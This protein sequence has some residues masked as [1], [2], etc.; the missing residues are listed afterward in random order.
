M[1][2]GAEQNAPTTNYLFDFIYLDRNKLGS[3]YAQLFDDGVLS[4]V[5]R[6]ASTQD[7]SARS[8]GVGAPK[9]LLGGEARSSETASNGIETQFDASW[10][11]PIEVINEL[12]SRGFIAKNIST[13]QLGQLVLLRGRLQIIDLRM[14]QELWEPIIAAQTEEAK[15][16]AKTALE[17]KTAATEAATNKQMIKVISKLPHTMQMR[18][19]NDEYQAWSTLSPSSLT[20]NA[21]DLA[22]KHGASMPG[23]WWTLALLDAR[24]ADDD[25]FAV[26][27]AL[28]DIESGMLQMLIGLRVFFGRQSRDY[29]VTPVAV[30]RSVSPQASLV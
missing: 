28:S 15:S 4:S 19:F 14:V 13:A 16:S 5:K 18:L 2:S 12:D 7:L 20:I 27:D 29:G 8:L 22:F 25:N 17:R 9:L 1:K 24:P 3:Y 21:E 23:E 30:F 10:T 6:T 26:P 11:I